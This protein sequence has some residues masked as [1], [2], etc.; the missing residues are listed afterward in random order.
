MDALPTKLSGQLRI[1]FPQC[2]NV[3]LVSGDLSP[4]CQVATPSDTHNMPYLHYFEPTGLHMLAIAFCLLVIVLVRITE[5]GTFVQTTDFQTSYSEQGK[6]NSGITRKPS[7][8]IFT[9]RK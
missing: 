8:N 9:K 6:L 7:T 2:P 1:Q 4:T 3:P 5:V